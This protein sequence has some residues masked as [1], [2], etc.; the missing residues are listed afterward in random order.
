M[1]ETAPKLLFVCL[2]NICRSPAA[3]GVM[4]ARLGAE[5][6]RA[7]DSAGTSGWHIGD[8]PYPPMIDCARRRGIDLRPIRARG[9]VADDF[10]SFEL[11]LAMDRTNLRDIETIRPA[12]NSTPVRLFLSYAPQIGL[13]DVPDPYYTGDFDRTLDLIEAAAEGLLATLG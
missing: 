9:F 1:Q 11:I 4:R 3:E 7:L 2:G 12:G 10:E 13:K 8:T 6:G 5:R